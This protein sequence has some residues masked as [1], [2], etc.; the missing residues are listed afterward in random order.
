MDIKELKSKYNLSNNDFW[1]LKQNS[2]TWIISHDACEKIAA[3]EGIE[4]VKIE[5]LNSERDFCRYLITMKKGE[6][7]ITSTGE[8]EIINT[9]KV[10]SMSWEMKKWIEEWKKF[11]NCQSNYPGAMAEKR[12]IDRCILKLIDAYQYGIYSSSESDDFKKT[13][14]KKEKVYQLE[15]FENMNKEEAK[16][17]LNEIT[18]LHSQYEEI[19]EFFT[20]K[21]KTNKGVNNVKGS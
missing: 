8:A 13:K 11:G 17:F 20:L 10:W 18:K 1:K 12:G 16:E 21:F 19:L 9:K 15:E 5:V 3:V 7:Q 6:K 14:G 4:L 2:N